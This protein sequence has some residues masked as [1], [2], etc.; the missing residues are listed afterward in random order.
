M[1][2]AD[3]APLW[4]CPLCRRS[5][6]LVDPDD[7][8]TLCP[9]CDPTR[10]GADVPPRGD[11]GKQRQS[12]GKYLLVL[13]LVLA[14]SGGGFYLSRLFLVVPATPAGPHPSLTETPAE[15][16][17]TPA[18]DRTETG[19]DRMAELLAKVDAGVVEIQADGIPLGSGFFVGDKRTICTNYHVV[20]GRSALEVRSAGGSVERVA[21]WL[22]VEP[23]HD[24]ALLRVARAMPETQPLEIAGRPPER[25]KSVFALGSPRGLTGSV[26]TGI[27]SAIRATDDFRSM[28]SPTEHG[29]ANYAPGAVWVQTTAPISPGNSGG[30]LV[31]EHGAVV[32][33]N[34]F[35]LQGQNLNF[36]ISSQ[37]LIE[38]MPAVGGNVRS[39]SELPKW[40]VPI[41]AKRQEMPSP[42]KEPSPAASTVAAIERQRELDRVQQ[43]IVQLRAEIAVLDS[44][45]RKLVA[46]RSRVVSTGRAVGVAIARTNAQITRSQ[47][48]LVALDAAIQRRQLYLNG[49]L[50]TLDNENAPLNEIGILQLQNEQA[51]IQVGLTTLAG[52]MKTLEANYIAHDQQAQGLFA[53]IA[54]H[55]IGRGLKAQELQGL[56]QKYAALQKPSQD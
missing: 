7:P 17:P 52:E 38:M 31:D 10:R 43:R 13:G 15:E 37:H 5:Y 27:V 28:L 26:S 46:E 2:Q 4:S 22:A 18:A 20:E 47:L 3:S 29:R 16:G 6:P 34:T 23:R 55:Q 42:K 11:G 12:A 56:E 21:G 53:Q 8:P 35:R 1:P 9:H 25:G 24:L 51:L 40:P 32:A 49:G 48:R 36:A 39:L 54:A 44:D 50:V 41:I 30:P 14:A 19:G 45:A 33:I